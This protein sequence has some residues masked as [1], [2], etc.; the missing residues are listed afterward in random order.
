MK[1]PLFFLKSGGG[2]DVLS[3]QRGL[4][5][6]PVDNH[7]RARWSWLIG[8]ALF[9]ALSLSACG[10]MPDGMFEQSDT[11]FVPP[12]PPGART[13]TEPN[14]EADETEIAVNVTPPTSRPIRLFWVNSYTDDHRRSL[15]IQSGLLE[16]LARRGYSVVDG[17]LELGV[18]HMG[19]THDARPFRSDSEDNEALVVDPQDIENAIVAI[20]TFQP[21]MVVVSDEE[22]ISAVIPNYPDPNMRFVY[23]GLRGE[24]QLYGVSRPNAAGVLEQVYP[25]KTVLIAR[26]FTGANPG[27]ENYFVVGDS[28]KSGWASVDAVVAALEVDKSLIAPPIWKLSTDRWVLWQK[29]IKDSVAAFD[30]P[31]GISGVDFILLARYHLLRDEAGR[32]IPEQEVITWLVQNSPV[33]VFG[34]WD[35]TVSDGAVGGLVVS[36]YDQGAAA[37]NIVLRLAGGT[38]PSSVLAKFPANRLF[39]INLASAKYWDL[40]IPVEFPTA[41]RIYRSVPGLEGGK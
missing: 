39:A 26:E 14:A 4:D 19:I 41:A 21:D 29:A 27:S 1:S 16:T 2:R 5:N 36:A 31:G 40:R 32:Y 24:P 34:L 13:L 33:P 23:C 25:V 18:F 35:Y 20:Q 12:V 8:L 3:L 22:A 37:A 17:N 15:Q 6:L 38:H 30:K 7:R 10:S 11:P 28:T 9:I